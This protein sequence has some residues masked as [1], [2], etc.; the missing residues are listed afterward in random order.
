MSLIPVLA[1]GC[2]AAVALLFLAGCVS[3]R[4]NWDARVGTYTYDQA[5]LELGPPDK[6]EQLGDGVIV[7]EWLT[8]S[9]RARIYSAYGYGP[10]SYW[11]YGP[12]YAPSVESWAPDY[13]IRLVFNRDGRLQSW[14]K[15]A[16]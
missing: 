8:H 5:V 12:L 10:G 3:A 9:G 1:R 4:I 7:A 6:K 2:I 14:K 11:G 16:K 13:F 15:F